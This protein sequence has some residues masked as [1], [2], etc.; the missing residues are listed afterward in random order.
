MSTKRTKRYGSRASRAPYPFEGGY[1]LERVDGGT[2]VT[3]FLNVQPSGIL[4]D[5]STYRVWQLFYMSGAAYYFDIGRLN[6][7]QA[8]LWKPTADG[9]STEPWSRA[10]LYGILSEEFPGAASGK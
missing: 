6:V 1:T 5:E 10:Y 4:V 2:K 9:R 3:F 7:Y 8:L